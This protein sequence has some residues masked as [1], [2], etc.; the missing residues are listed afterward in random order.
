MVSH[1]GPVAATL[2]LLLP[3]LSADVEGLQEL[4]SFLPFPHVTGLEF[5]NVET[6]PLC[7]VEKEWR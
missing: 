2:D 3:A 6:R 5:G 7:N 4:E 1:E